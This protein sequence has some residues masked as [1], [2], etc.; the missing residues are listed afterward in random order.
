MGGIVMKKL[1]N[2]IYGIST[3]LA[4]SFAVSCEDF[5]LGDGFLQK[6]P[7]NDVTIDTVFS[8]KEYAVRV[9]WKSYSQLPYGHW[10]GWNLS[11]GMWV[12]N[13]ENLTD[14][15]QA[16][17]GY[18]GPESI[19]YSGQYNSGTEDKGGAAGATKY[20]FRDMGA[21]KGIRQAWLFYENVHRVP[22][23]SP[24]EKA[25]LR[26]EAKILVAL[27]YIEMIRNYGS[28]PILDHAISP[29]EVNLP[30]RATLQEN[31]D[32]VVSLLDD[33]IATPEL[34]WALAEDEITNWAGRLTKASAMGLKARLLLFV[35]SPL[36]NSPEP[37]FA[38]TASSEKMTWFGDFKQERW[39]AA[40]KACE[41]FFNEL[42][43]KGGYELDKDTSD[44][45]LGF[46]KAYFTPG[47]K[48][49]LVSSRRYK[50]STDNKF[51]MQSSRWGGLCPTKEY[52]DMFPMKDGS[53]FDWKDASKAAN[54]FVG[55]DPRLS[56]TILL[57]GDIFGSG[58]A[59]VVKQ[60]ADDKA[61]YPAG[62]H[63]G[64]KGILDSKSLSSG[65]A[66][67]KFALDRQGEYNK[68]PVHWPV[69]RLAELYLSYAEALNEC[70]KTSEAYEYVN[71]VRDR[72]NVGHLK[73]GLD[74]EAFREAVLRERACEF[75]WEEVRFYDM[76]R[77]KREEDF[78]KPLH[79]MFVYRHKTTSEYK[80]DFTQMSK[81]A[82]QGDGFSAKWYLSAFPL[83][84][85]K[86]GYGL[87][88]NPGWE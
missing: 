27:Q 49:I 39:E 73:A 22:D 59:D 19:Y 23:M 77:W 2:I 45:R 70:G 52:F 51:F 17:V 8:T 5:A 13:L 14:L 25:R 62:Q 69:L 32:F 76:I 57:D 56:E 15:S 21:W 4:L 79:N 24:A 3:L 41:D 82:W 12:G 81:R 29:D 61:N 48:G 80:F 58:K 87:V 46:R 28:V 72:V 88:Q 54:P 67:R 68:Q 74:K 84:E 47:A 26:A 85:V 78:K 1:K 50:R 18:G 38:G 71:A 35:A 83:S 16:Y 30:K 33:A 55:R 86:K 63:W 37:Y 6:P 66:G 7:S 64:L 44:P 40:L 34:P 42:K 53:D 31:V 60:K 36:F 65:I 20:R 43:I 10:T 75:G 9:L 11:T